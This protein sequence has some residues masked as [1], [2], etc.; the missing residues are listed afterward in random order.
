MAHQYSR[1]G[2][3]SSVKVNEVNLSLYYGGVLIH[4]IIHKK[5]KKKK[6]KNES[7]PN[8]DPLKMVKHDVFEP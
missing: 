4:M 5:K 1:V 6:K 2:F 8:A 3:D 7:P